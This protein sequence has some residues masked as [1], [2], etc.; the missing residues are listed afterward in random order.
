MK[1]P[2]F[3]NSSFILSVCFV[4]FAVCESVP[5]AA[6]VDANV[7]NAVEKKVHD[8]RDA[9]TSNPYGYHYA[10]ANPHAYS[11]AYHYQYHNAAPYGSYGSYG[12]YPQTNYG[13]SGYGAYPGYSGYSSYPGYGGYAGAA[14]PGAGYSGYPGYSG[15]SGYGGYNKAY[16]YTNGYS[17]GY[18][19]GYPYSTYG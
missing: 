7:G 12:T 3:M 5:N 11:T 16:P 10:S 14:Y 18:R 17:N 15:Y 6:P 8:K 2:S 19:S 13:S 1:M 4:A 9:V